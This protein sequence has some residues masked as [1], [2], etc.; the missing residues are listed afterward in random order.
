MGS[1]EVDKAN[2]ENL[3]EVKI[4]NNILENRATQNNDISL[5]YKNISIQNCN[6]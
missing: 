2:S 5:T 3:H 1:M 4:Y 6:I